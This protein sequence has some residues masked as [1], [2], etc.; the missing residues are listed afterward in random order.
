[1]AGIYVE[2]TKIRD[3]PVLTDNS[4]NPLWLVKVPKYV[5]DKFEKCESGQQFGIIQ[6]KRSQMGTKYS[7]ELDSKLTQNTDGTPSCPLQ[8]DMVLGQLAGSNKALA[9][10][11][12]NDDTINIEGIV[13][14][15]FDIRPPKDQR[16]YIAL[17]SYVAEKALE[18]I[19]RTQHFDGVVQNYKPVNVPLHKLGQSSREL[20]EKKIANKRIR[21]EKDQ[22]EHLLLSAFQKHQYYT[23]KQLVAVTKQP[24]QYLKEFLNEMCVYNTKPPHKFMWELKPEYRHYENVEKE[25]A[26]EMT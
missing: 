11:S 10:Y 24:E 14:A 12:D 9:A 18:P 7:F 25:E 21:L 19:R 2:Q 20:K 15:K 22:V 8:H 23:Q 17:K 6:T 16:S 13:K 1:M 3:K 5:A 26:E 4:G